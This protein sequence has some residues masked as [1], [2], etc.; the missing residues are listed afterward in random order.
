MILANIAINSPQ[1]S[2][3]FVFS[4][5]WNPNFYVFVLSTWASQEREIVQAV[6]CQRLTA[7]AC[8]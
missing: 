3:L 8:V 4:V 2:Y 5:M 7:E 1:N 6:S